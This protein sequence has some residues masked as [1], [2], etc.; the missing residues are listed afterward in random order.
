VLISPSGQV[1]VADFGI[2]RALGADPDSN[3]TQAGSVMG[4]ATYFA[5]EQAQGLPLDPRSDLYSLGVVL[6]EMTTGRPPFSGESPVAIAYKHV[7]EQ[8][9]PPRHVNTNVPT[10]LEAIILKLLSKNPQARYPSAE[11]LRA[12]LRRF[13]E[14][15]PV[16]AVAGAAGGG[17]AAAGATQAMAATQAVH[18][19]EGTRVVPVADYP[20]GYSEPRRS[21]AFLVV[22]ILLLLI[23]GGLLF[24][25]AKVISGG[26]SGGATVDITVPQNGVVG[27]PE[28]VATKALQVAGFDVTPLHEKNDTVAEGMV[29]SVD[30]PEGTTVKVDQGKRGSATLHVSAGANTVKMPGVVGQLKD[31]AI[32]FLK[33]QGFTNVVTQDGTSEDPKVQ[34]GEVIA[35]EPAVGQDI[36]KDAVVTLTIS[37][38]KPKVK[39]PGV[40]GKTVDQARTALRAVGLIDAPGTKDSPSDTVEK[41]TV[42]G[43]EPAEGAEVDKGSTVTIVVSS[44]KPQVSVPSVTGLTKAGAES[45]ITN[46][47]LVPQ[48]TC[49]VNAAA[50]SKGEVTSQS[51]AKDTKV[52]KGSVVKFDF[53]APVCA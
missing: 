32:N 42:I 39:I 26:G 10:A 29:V 41:G 46:A 20:G 52:D 3:L 2:A 35:Q 14:G 15:Q 33:S 13:G 1:K 11:D 36:K 22:L 30:P 50:P 18:G 12:D 34:I 37:T 16:L 47:G 6:Y 44:G 8:P 17:A 27:K 53:D 4:T 31:A 40:G 49:H 25:L 21:G 43:T 51:P 23:L 28:D 9:A 38:G 48:G 19:V 5:P 45:T 7:Q 24:A